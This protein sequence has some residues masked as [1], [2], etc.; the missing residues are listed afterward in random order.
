MKNKG[1]ITFFMLIIILNTWW[2]L[3]RDEPETQPQEGVLD[4]WVTWGDSPEQ[5]QLLFDRFSESNGI[6]VQV[7]TQVRE[8]DLMETMTGSHP[9]DLVILSSNQLVQIAAEQ[10]LIEPLEPWIEI[11]G[12]NLDDIYP[13]SLAQCVNP[14]SITLCLPWGSDVFALYWNK[15]LFAA[16]GLDPEHPPQTMGELAQYAKKLT[17]V[18]ADGNLI[19]MG[20]MPDFPRSHNDLYASM[21]GGLWLNHGGTEV[22]ANSK[23]VI[24]ALNWESQFFEGYETGEMKQFA[25]SVNGFINSNHSV[26]GGVRLNCQQCH[27]VKPQNGDKVPDHSFYDG[28]VAMMVDGQWQM[29]AAYI[30]HYQP[31]LNYG[32]APFPF[33][34]DHPER[35]NTSNVQ[36]PVVVLPTGAADQRMAAKLLAWMM[37][38]EIVAE[39]SLTNAMLPT[40]QIAA[41]DT[42]FQAIPYFDVFLDLLNNPNAQFIPA[43]SVSVK[44]NAAMCKV[45]KTALYQENRTPGTLLDGIQREFTP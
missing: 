37:S 39:I 34:A 36:G 10:D 31:D 2:F 12:I 5:L 15:D 20:F 32:V 28:K 4:V 16:A 18:D 42:R 43:S 38:P 17:L 22:T 33:P 24:E 8:D 41:Q 40:S 13:V 3:L 26:F 19:R 45:E 1:Y 27:R 25:L 14:E 21:F 7:T 6:S 44:L 35:K 9:P 11:A 29:G 23:P 30:T